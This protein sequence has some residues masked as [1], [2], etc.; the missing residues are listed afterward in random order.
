MT[1][2]HKTGTVETQSLTTVQKSLLIVL[3]I[4]LLVGVGVSIDLTYIHYKVVTDVTGEYQSFCNIN[5]SLN[6]DAVAQTSWAKFLG[7]PIALLGL[8][9]YLFSLVLV[10]ARWRSKLGKSPHTAIYLFWVGAFSLLY[11][12]FLAYVCY[13]EIGSW[14]I[15]C[16]VLYGV[17]VLYFVLAFLTNNIPVRRHFELKMQDWR[18]LWADGRKRAAFVV[19]LLAIGLLFGLSNWYNHS[20]KQ[21]RIAAVMSK[22]KL[23]P[24]P[25]EAVGD[26]SGN[27]DGTIS[28][29]IFSDYM[30]PFCKQMED[31]LE[32]LTHEYKQLKVIRRDF[33]LDMACNP[34]LQ[35]PFHKYACEAASIKNCA[36]Q[37]GQGKQMHHLLLENQK[38]LGPG[39]FEQAIDTLKLDR[40]KLKACMTDSESRFYLRRDIS[41]GIEIGLNGTP[42]MVIN[43]THLVVGGISREELVR[44]IELNSDI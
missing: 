16:L 38:E 24:K 36:G 23:L 19:V 13:A 14:C 1:A 40:E 3:A 41:A 33:P 25:V 32:A 7:V 2:F 26:I 15:M 29:I 9:T 44:L 18:W 42:T 27:P 20:L 30:C 10:V 28:V 39:L 21:E 34:I 12:I 5:E 8:L 17:N 4:T 31:M 35:Q 37:Q 43:G 22:L 11:S 6:C